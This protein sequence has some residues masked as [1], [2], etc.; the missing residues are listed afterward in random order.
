MK[1]GRLGRQRSEPARDTEQNKAVKAVKPT[2]RSTIGA[3]TGDPLRSLPARK[4]NNESFTCIA[5][6][7]LIVVFI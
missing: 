1:T 4:D 6:N 3:D 7:R 5:L 2:Q